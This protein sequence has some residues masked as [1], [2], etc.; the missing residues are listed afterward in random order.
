MSRG[1]GDVYKRQPDNMMAIFNRGLL[2]D[3]T[4]DYKGA[5]KDYSTVINEYPNFVIG[6]Q[7][8]AQ[9]R[10]KVGDI[11]GADADEFKV[12][13]A[14]LD[15]QNGVSQ[16]NQTAD[17]SESGNRTRKKSDKNM[18]NYRKIVVADNEEGEEK[19]KSE[20]RGRVQ[21]KNVTIVPQP[22]FVLTYYEKHNDVKR[23]VNYHKY[24][25]ELN[26]NKVLPCLLYTSPSP[27][28]TR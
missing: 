19:Y 1:L 12:L 22:M 7:Y 26:S 13:K 25:E 16:N 5:I 8:R 27:R 28:D 4:G 21:D 20:Y 15:K 23:Q 2:R 9:A 18:N 14:Q 10:K 3:Q 24:I 11:K 6:Y 17:N